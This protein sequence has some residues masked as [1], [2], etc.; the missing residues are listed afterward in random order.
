LYFLNCGFIDSVFSVHCP[1]WPDEASEWVTRERC[2]GFLQKSLMKR[3]I[4]FSCNLVNM[5]PKSVLRTEENS[6]ANIDKNIYWRFSFSMAEYLIIHSMTSPQRVAYRTLRS[7]Y[8]NILSKQQDTS[9]LCTYYFKTLILWEC[10]RKPPQFG[11][12]ETMQFVNYWRK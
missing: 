10:E 11:H 1:Y 4:R 3:N 7:L 2:Y 8:K 12:K 6:T 9:V 5:S